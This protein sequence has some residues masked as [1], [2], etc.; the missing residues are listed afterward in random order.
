MASKVHT[1]TPNARVRC[2]GACTLVHEKRTR[3]A[4]LHKGMG[5]GLL[6]QHEGGGGP[7]RRTK[8]TARPSGEEQRGYGK[9]PAECAVR[10]HLLDVQ[11]RPMMPL[12]V[13]LMWSSMAVAPTVRALPC[14]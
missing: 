10:A 3:W 2:V 8:R 12:D 6:W 1:E 13:T 11:Q 5:R 4:F 14:G 7:A 9:T